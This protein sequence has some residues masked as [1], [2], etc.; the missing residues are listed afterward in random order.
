VLPPCTLQSCWRQGMRIRRLRG[1]RWLPAVLLLGCSSVTVHEAAGE[2]DAAVVP[3][4]AGEPDA[5]APEAAA[6][7]C[8]Q[9]ASESTCVPVAT[10]CSKGVRYACYGPPCPSG[11][12]GSCSVVSTGPPPGYAEVCCERAAC[13]RDTFADHECTAHLDGAPLDGGAGLRMWA[14]PPAAKP[15]G[16]CAL[17][18]AGVAEHDY[19]CR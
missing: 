2:P 16:S 9:D 5:D 17:Y 6:P 3:V 11:D 19:C 4:E 15:P 7:G 18:G 13:V 10:P 12:V 8:P 14:C 1:M